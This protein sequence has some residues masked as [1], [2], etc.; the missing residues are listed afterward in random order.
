MN[1]LT[2]V[3][4]GLSL[5]L[6]PVGITKLVKAQDSLEF[7]T[8]KISSG[9]AGCPKGTF[10]VSA[11]GNEIS[12]IFNSFQA[13]APKGGVANASCNLRVPVKVPVGYTIQ[14]ITVVSTGFADIPTGGSGAIDTKVVAGTSTLGAKSAQFG[15]GY[16]ATY[17]LTTKAGAQ[18]FNA[19]ASPKTAILGLNTSLIARAINAQG[20]TLVNLSTQDVRSEGKLQL[21]FSATRC[22]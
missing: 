21:I 14:E 20:P 15:A 11:F 1:R 2:K 13:V 3:A 10:D 22:N 6:I 18:T 19:C 16:S 17:Q 5:L 8:D 7:F 9:G 4:L 12:I